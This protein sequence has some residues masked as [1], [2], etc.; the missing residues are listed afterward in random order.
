MI[1]NL[2]RL[3]S[4]IFH[5]LFLFYYLIILAYWMNPYAFRIDKPKDFGLIWIMSFLILVFFPLLTIVLMKALK[6]ISSFAMPDKQ[7]RIGPM[8]ASIV[9]YVWFFINVKND[10]PFPAHIVMLALGATICLCVSFF[11]NNFSKVSLHTAGAGA[12]MSGIGLMCFQFASP[13]KILSIGQSG[14]A[15]SPMTV[16]FLSILL[17]G[18]IGTS[19][20]L[21]KAH[22]TDDLYGGYIIGI[23]SMLIAYKIII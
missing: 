18:A 21:L 1:I 9:F 22:K 11:V 6:M 20:L 4:Y 12:F 7:D 2:A 14:W 10:G 15:V 17:S 13:Y 8:I 3:I 5:P 19:R 16:L 23:S